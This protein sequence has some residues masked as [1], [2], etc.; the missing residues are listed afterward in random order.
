[1][2]VLALDTT[3]RAGSAAIVADGA[4][5]LE[6]A[7]DAGLTHGE[8]LPGELI[9]LVS[10][11]GASLADVDL[12]AVAAGP[13]SFTG[14]RVGIA[15]VQGLAMALG[16]R[17]VAVSALDALARAAGE[18]SEPIA[19]WMDAQRGEVF[20]ALYERTGRGRLIEPAALPPDETLRSWRPQ[21][22][23]GPLRVIGDG[24]LRYDAVG[25]A[26]GLDAR[27]LPGVTP[28]AGVIGIM[29]TERAADA[30]HPHAILP[31]YVRRPDAEIARARRSGTP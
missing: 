4:I 25:R 6:Q 7:G 29:A 17:V 8:R 11:A 1:V 31:V 20:S 10:T 18:G 15:T 13:G 30:V 5:R 19:V 12:L 3:T 26:S 27:I 23:H 28:L 22:P 21:L 2:L 24:A 16:R 14:I 9:G